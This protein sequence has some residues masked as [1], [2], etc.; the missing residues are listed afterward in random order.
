MPTLTDFTWR[1][2]ILFLPGIISFI[3]YR[4]ISGNA[5]L[6]TFKFLVY[7]AFWGIIDYF[8]LECIYIL[9]ADREFI[10]DFG[11]YSPIWQYFNYRYTEIPLYQIVYAIMLGSVLALIAGLVSW[12][13]YSSWF[14]KYIGKYSYNV[15]LWYYTLSAETD[16]GRE[17]RVT[18]IDYKNQC[19]YNGVIKSFS[20]LDEKREI[21]LEQATVKTK[22]YNNNRIYNNKKTN[23]N[24]NN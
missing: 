5:P 16:M 11:S 24:I 8:M 1:L 3:I 13:R 17:R 10:S 19:E 12:F 9:Y 20:I 15:N 2:F 21:V 14:I 22:N 4:H 23:K 18:I 6:Q 7:S